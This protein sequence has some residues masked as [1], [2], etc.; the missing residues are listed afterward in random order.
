MPSV[1]CVRESHYF[2]ECVQN[3]SSRQSVLYLFPNIIASLFVLVSFFLLFI[4]VVLSDSEPGH[5]VKMS[6]KGKTDP[7]LKRQH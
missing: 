3:T 2:I 5:D 6:I 4:I 7:I 1:C